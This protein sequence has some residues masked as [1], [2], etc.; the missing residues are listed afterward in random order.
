MLRTLELTC[1]LTNGNTAI[2]HHRKLGVMFHGLFMSDMAARHPALFDLL[3]QPGNHLRPFKLSWPHISPE[4]LVTWKIQSLNA[5]MSDY[6]GILAEAPT[7]EWRLEKLDCN[8]RH[9][10]LTL[11]D[12]QSYSHFAS[13]YFNGQSSQVRHAQLIFQSPTTFKWSANNHYYPLP[14]PRLIL[15][16]GLNKWNA[17]SDRVRLE[18]PNLLDTLIENF[19]IADFQLHHRLVSIDKGVIPAFAGHLNVTLGGPTALKELTLLLLNY[20]TL[21]GVGAKAQMGLGDLRIHYQLEES[22]A[23]GTQNHPAFAG[24]NH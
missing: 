16:S 4:G 11:S 6:L 12:P 20:E 2:K 17:F 9:L 24:R 19:R 7:S 15:Q 1:Q 13:R 14:D 3:H 5:Q 18:D 21:C 23:H 22:L 10:G 8:M